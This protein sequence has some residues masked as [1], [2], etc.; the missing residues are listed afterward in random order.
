MAQQSDTA[1]GKAALSACGID[2]RPVD[3]APGNGGCADDKP[4]RC[5]AGQAVAG[6]G[7]RD[8]LVH[9]ARG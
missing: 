9:G 5:G 2:S 1:A 8:A 6:E 4:A 3:K 7:L